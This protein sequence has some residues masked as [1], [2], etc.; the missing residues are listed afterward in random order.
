M[1]KFT[2]IGFS[3]A[4]VS[5]IGGWIFAYNPTMAIVFG[6]IKNLGLI[7]YAYVTISLFASALDNVEYRTGM[8]LD[9]MLGVAMIGLVT[10]LLSSP[11]GGMYETVLLAKGFDG[12]L[13]AQTTQVTGWISFC[14]WGL[15]ILTAIIYI[16]TMSVY[17]IDKKLPEINAAL[18]E[19]RRQAVLDA[20]EE[21]V[22]P[23]ELERREREEIA[24]EHEKNR[25]AD[26]KARCARQGLDFE[27]E[28]RKYI[29]KQER[30]KKKVKSK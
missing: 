30:K 4:L 27:T 5:G 29:E 16:V 9:G 21:W 8:R 12:Q 10:G 18:L 11:F 20:G 13:A 24:A 14:F 17:D 28:N 26:L 3:L 19:R 7:P 23:E 15:D 1:R 25:I 6:F 22:E 2:I